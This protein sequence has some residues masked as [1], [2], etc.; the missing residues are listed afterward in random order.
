MIK[1]D[2]LLKA[3][4][5]MW[6]SYV[7]TIAFTVYLLLTII[8]IFADQDNVP[9]LSAISIK[10]GNASDST[11]DWDSWVV[12]LVNMVIMLIYLSQ[13]VFL[14]YHKGTLKVNTSK[15]IRS[16]AMHH[17]IVF[18]IVSLIF[19]VVNIIYL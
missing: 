5:V 6:M 18:S 19:F 7:F 14:M 11:R 15:T 4:Y 3:K 13:T 1:N 12:R 9:V 16:C 17:L 10:L 2:T 8:F